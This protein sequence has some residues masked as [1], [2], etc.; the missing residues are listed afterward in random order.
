MTPL[1]GDPELELTTLITTLKRWT[2]EEWTSLSTLFESKL[3]A[4]RQYL[5]K[6]DERSAYAQMWVQEATEVVDSGKAGEM[7]K[8]LEP[9][10]EDVRNK[11]SQAYQKWGEN[12]DFEMAGDAEKTRHKRDK[13]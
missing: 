4:A 7:S 8:L 9:E 3:S 11:L 12:T 5:S 6:D 1:L 2:E 10:W 13:R